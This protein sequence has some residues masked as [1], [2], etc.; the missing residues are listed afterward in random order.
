[1][2]L[3]SAYARPERLQQWTSGMPD[4][5]L[6]V[7]TY[8]AGASLA[9]VTLV[10]VFG[11][12]FFLDGDSAVARKKG[13]VGLT[14]PANDCFINSV[15]QSLA[16]LGELRVYLI[17]EVHRRRLDGPGVYAVDEDYVP[18]GKGPG[19][20]KLEGLRRGLVTRALKDVLDSLNERPIHRKTISAGPFIR[21]LEQAFRQTIS[22]Q[23]QD[24]QEFLQVV[25]ERLSE[26]YHAGRKARGQARA[27]AR[28]KTEDA[29]AALEQL[30]L[31]DTTSPARPSDDRP[32]EDGEVSSAPEEQVAPKQTDVDQTALKAAVG[33]DNDNE[34]LTE[35]TEE[36]VPPPEKKL[37]QTEAKDEEVETIAKKEVGV[38]GK[39]SEDPTV[40][41]VQEAESRADEEEE[42]DE[43]GFPLEGKLESQIECETCHFK[44]KPSVSTF[45]TLTLNVPLQNSTLND[46]FDGLFKTEHIDDFR[47][48]KCR[49]A[50]AVHARSVDLAAGKS[51]EEKSRIS[52][53]IA[54][55][56]EVMKRNPETP[57]EGLHLPAL[58]LAPKRRISRHIR[59][60]SFPKIVAIHLS[61]SIFDPR[62]ISRK[63]SAKVAFPERLS[64]G[65][66]LNRKEY[67]LLGVVTHKGNH[68]SGH[69]ES[70]R[71]QNLYPPFSTPHT[72]GPSSAYSASATPV[73]SSASSPEIGATETPDGL[74]P[75]PIATP[76][77]PDASSVSAHSS[78]LSSASS[79][80]TH[81]PSLSTS[82]ERN[83]PAALGPAP[84][85]APRDSLESKPP[86]SPS[87]S[88]SAPR[89]SS[90]GFSFKTLSSS[91][92][93]S[94]ST[95]GARPPSSPSNAPPPSSDSN[96]PPSSPPDLVRLGTGASGN[97]NGRHRA[98]RDKKRAQRKRP[99]DRW[100]RISDDKVKEARTTDVL[101]MQKEVYLLFYEMARA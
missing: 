97:G 1:M 41:E 45:V 54:K 74:P 73:P 89:D 22:R 59:I 62:S 81:R 4:R 98:S 78:S 13:V 3:L 29:L 49:L 57:P 46:C 14:N 26:E 19:A 39:K 25:A 2:D 61:R 50:H 7:A 87:T 60:T 56:E 31:D 82:S 40:K 5:P 70:F 35:T 92:R 68:N 90:D 86:F 28:A 58:K 100:W 23:Q 75:L 71:R 44:P 101:A 20:A 38:S 27:R 8:A 55:I 48:D 16:G 67:K 42:A 63:N 52:V 95:N 83:K 65:G 36:N 91:I 34:E 84:T 53:D 12:T 79:L 85:S 18:E 9:A 69:Y 66:I 47:C 21:V 6:T 93:R 88:T 43:N 30:K 99:D 17:R 80:S 76:S 96:P 37:N 24:A 10:Y 64:L 33:K 15:L 72:L 77:G 94:R 51:D 32:R 11:P